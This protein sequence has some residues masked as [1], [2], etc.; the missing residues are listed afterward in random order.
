MCR[1]VGCALEAAIDLTA[2]SGV[3]LRHLRE[4]LATDVDVAR[5]LVFAAGSPS[6]TPD[7]LRLAREHL[8]AL[9]S[10]PEIGVGTRLDL[11]QIH[12]FPP[13]ESTLL[14]W[15]MNPQAHSWDITSL[16]ET[17]PAAGEQ[18]RTVRARR[19]NASIAVSPVTLGPREWEADTRAGLH[20]LY[21]SHF[22]AAWTVATAKHLAEAGASSVTLFNRLDIVTGDTPLAAILPALC[23]ANGDMVTPTTASHD[24]IASLCLRAEATAL[25]FL[26]NL[27]PKDQKVRLPAASR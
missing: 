27:T 16:A 11:Y 17:P 8:G 7:V 18:V 13:P 20:P 4:A 25:L 19:P 9:T 15:T 24:G 23:H 22:A 2:D 3:E 26:A 14:N 21:E 6:T 1:R 10:R 5:V 12:L